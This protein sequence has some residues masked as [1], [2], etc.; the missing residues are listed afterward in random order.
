MRNV[1][2]L[3]RLAFVG[4][5]VLA[6]SCGDGESRPIIEDR[7]NIAETQQALIT[8]GG[9]LRFILDQIIIAEKSRTIPLPDLPELAG[10]LLPFGLRTVNGSFNNLLPGQ[11]L[12]GSADR[13]FP[14]LTT[15]AFRQAEVVVFDLDGPGPVNVGNSTSYTQTTGAV[16]DAQPRIISNLVVD[17]SL[18]NPAAVAAAAA[19]T[20]TFPGSTV[21]A[22]GIFFI[23]NVA[24]D[25]G[26][27][28]PYNSW[29][30]LFGQFFDHGLDLVNKGGSGTI[31]V[32]LQP[33]D[34][35][36]VPGSPTN[37]MVLTRAS[38][39]PGPDGIRGTADDVHEHRNQTTPFVDQNQTYTSHASHQVFLREYVLSAGGPVAT[40]R[41]LD[42]DRGGIGNWAYV[43]T[44]AA[45]M[46]GIGLTDADIFNVPLLA[47]DAYGMFVRG[48][49][50]LAQLVTPGGLVEGNLAVPV[51]TVNAFSRP[52]YF[53]EFINLGTSGPILD[54]PTTLL[55]D[56]NESELLIRMP[57]GTI[58]Y[59]GMEHIVMGGTVNNDKMRASDGDDTL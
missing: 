45:A 8:D 21:D 13:I 49:N 42:G 6:C 11:Q 44:Q 22:N 58:R 23:P 56:Q 18:D 40:G 14:R 35:L 46:L 43:K 20:T 55:A 28:A 17:Q 1:D 24:P 57:D 19:T 36:F 2:T 26:L 39:E 53:F 25:V 7:E 37:F 15:P 27:S 51:G 38:N 34:P 32:P 48:P 30:T 54:D 33:D 9:D 12:F 52:R 29:F 47:T 5:G 16:F 31:F 50:G 59:T 10:P 41:L 3:L 4:S